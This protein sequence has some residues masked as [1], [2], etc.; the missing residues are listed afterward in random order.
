MEHKT[1]SYD[2]FGINGYDEYLTRLA[3]FTDS[4]PEEQRA[5]F[6]PLFAAA[7]ELLA[8]ARRM[9]DALR[10]GDPQYSLSAEE[11]MALNAL[12]DAIDAAWGIK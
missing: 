9:V 5:E 6:G 7:P 3:T 11:G 8:A 12:D 10:G 4:M 2:G 1:L